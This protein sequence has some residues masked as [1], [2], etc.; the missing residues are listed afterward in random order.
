LPWGTTRPAHSADRAIEVTVRIDKLDLPADIQTALATVLREGVTNLLRHSKAEHCEIVLAGAPGLVELDI[1]IDGAAAEQR[2]GEG[3]GLGNLTTRVRA[4]GG[5]LQ[6][7]TTSLHT[8]RL[9][10]E[11]PLA[12]A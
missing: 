9:R 4:L 5:D 8:F 2:T 10:A 1:T 7:T 12:T 11:V 3:S 6:I